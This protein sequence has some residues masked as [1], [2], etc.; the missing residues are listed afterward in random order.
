ME[1]NTF[2]IYADSYDSPL[3]DYGAG[4]HCE[5]CGAILR[6]TNPR[7]ICDPCDAAMKAARNHE[8]RARVIDEDGT[9]SID[10][11]VLALLR[12]GDWWTGAKIGE[13]LGIRRQTVGDIIKRL[14]EAGHEIEAEAGVGTRLVRE[15]P[16][17]GPCRVGHVDRASGEVSWDDTKTVALNRRARS[18][19]GFSTPANATRVIGEIESLDGPTRKRVLLYCLGRWWNAPESGPNG[20]AAR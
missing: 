5:I 11:D 15:A 16:G 2:S 18:F 7:P 9:R 12:G 3:E 17:P 13:M 4:R 1:D 14:R 10:E 8:R 20:M 6:R 19:A